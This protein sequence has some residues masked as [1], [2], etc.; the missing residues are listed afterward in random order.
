MTTTTLC[1]MRFCLDF[2]TH[3][4]DK[5]GFY[6]TKHGVAV[7]D[8]AICIDRVPAEAFLQIAQ[9]PAAYHHAKCCTRAPDEAI[10]GIYIAS[11]AGIGEVCNNALLDCFKRADFVATKTV[12][13][14]LQDGGC[15]MYLPRT[16][17]TK[18]GG[19]KQQPV[20]DTQSKDDAT[21][22]HQQG[23]NGKSNSAADTIGKQ[24]EQEANGH[25]ASQGQSHE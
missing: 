2:A 7:E 16:D 22:G 15:C 10:P 5:C 13:Q 23:A 6:Q 25:V 18:N 21:A 24:H 3:S 17:D 8:D 14:R 1:E 20:V 4:Q 9:D 19:S 12:S 11:R